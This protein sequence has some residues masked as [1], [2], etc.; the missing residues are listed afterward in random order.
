MNFEIAIIRRRNPMSLFSFK[1][2]SINI[3]FVILI[4]PCLDDSPGNSTDLIPP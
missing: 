2:F 3:Q 4:K 1:H